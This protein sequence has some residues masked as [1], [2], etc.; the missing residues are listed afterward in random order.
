MH[1]CVGTVCLTLAAAPCLFAQIPNVQVKFDGL[2]HLRDGKGASPRF[3]AYDLWGKHSVITIELNIEPGFDLVLSQR[4]QPIEGDS[5]SGLVDE[6]TIADKGYWRVG[7]LYAVFGAGRVYRESALGAEF[8]LTVGSK[9]TPF[10]LTLL[11]ERAGRQRGVLARL[12]SKLGVSVALGEHFASNGSALTVIRRP[13]D[14]PGRD[15][16]YQFMAGVDYQ[17]RVLGG[18]L[19]LEHVSLRDGERDTDKDM[20]ISHIEFGRSIGAKWNA[21]ASLSQE[22]QS[23]STFVALSLSMNVYPSIFLEPIVRTRN[24]E[25]YDWGFGLRVK[26]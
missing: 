4:F 22:W 12:G 7:K 6:L 5:D 16:G 17:A 2:L 25:L 1:R 10:V 21:S 8:N 13:E 26:P 14:G 24:G 20:D 15:R 11:D 9:A 23:Q 18:R 3:K 19:L